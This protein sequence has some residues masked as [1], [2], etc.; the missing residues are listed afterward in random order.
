MALLRRTVRL[1]PAQRDAL[2]FDHHHPRL[3]L[4]AMFTLA[5]LWA[6]SE[7]WDPY[8]LRVL[9]EEAKKWEKKLG[10]YEGGS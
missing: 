8:W 4:G 6:E 1:A 9:N 7:F 3:M 10:K 2:F 5:Q